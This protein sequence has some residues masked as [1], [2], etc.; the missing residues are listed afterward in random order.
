[1]SFQI[2][3]NKLNTNNRHRTKYNLIK[4]KKNK[5]HP[6]CN[7]SRD[8]K[9]LIFIFV[10]ENKIFII[11]ILFGKFLWCGCKNLNFFIFFIFC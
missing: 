7:S 10:F 6:S 4:V 2:I 11:N 9:L 8:K 3:K 1:M 5:N